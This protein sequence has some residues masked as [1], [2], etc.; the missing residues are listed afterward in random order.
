MIKINLLSIKRKKKAVVLPPVFLRGLIVFAVIL[1]VVGYFSFYLTN[2]VSDMKAEK[3][4]KEKR[5]Y[6]LKDMIKEVEYYEKDNKAFEE[7]TKIIERLKKKQVIPLILLNEVS[8]LLPRGVWLNSLTDSGGNI[9]IGG[10]A[11]TNTDLV[12]Y[13]DNLKRSKYL[14]D[15]ALIESKQIL[16]GKASIMDPPTIYQFT[17][18]FRVRV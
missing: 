18:R 6:E 11:F 4:N 14:Q 17:L 8:V 1:I 9:K 5:L 10:Y 16:M 7:K 3:A 15:V 12:G 2:K 13:I